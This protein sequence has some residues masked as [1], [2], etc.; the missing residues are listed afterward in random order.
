[1]GAPLSM[2][3]Q[4][5]KEL[6]NIAIEV[7]RPGCCKTLQTEWNVIILLQQDKKI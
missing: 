1:M 7:I 2:T 6:E 5:M 3:E 4:M